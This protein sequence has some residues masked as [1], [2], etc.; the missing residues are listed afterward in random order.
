MVNVC[1]PVTAAESDPVRPRVAL[2]VMVVARKSR[3]VCV[4]MVWFCEILILCDPLLSLL[5]SVKN[6][7]IFTEGSKGSE[8]I[9]ELHSLLDS[10]D[11]HFFEKWVWQIEGRS[12]NKQLMR[13]CKNSNILLCALFIL[14]GKAEAVFADG[15]GNE[16]GFALLCDISRQ[17]WLRSKKSRT[18]MEQVRPGGLIPCGVT[19]RPCPSLRSASAFSSG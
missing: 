17:S 19:C 15:G 9:F 3:R 11:F 10:A 13:K 14:L 16:V 8:K 4:F 12:H 5:P 1:L 18:R 6:E 2:A 7:E